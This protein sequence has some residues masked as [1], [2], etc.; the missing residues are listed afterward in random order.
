VTQAEARY[1]TPFERS[2]VS[3]IDGHAGPPAQILL[4]IVR[5]LCEE[6]ARRDR[7]SSLPTDAKVGAPGVRDPE[8]PCDQYDPTPSEIGAHGECEGECETD[9][10][11]LCRGCRWRIKT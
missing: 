10:H 11:Y 6:L 5:R 3:A 9:G 1:L 8:H 4:Q 7:V 2:A